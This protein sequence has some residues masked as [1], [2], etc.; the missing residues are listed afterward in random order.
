MP[1]DFSTQCAPLPI[2]SSITFGV[3]L[4]RAFAR[5]GTRASLDVFIRTVREDGPASLKK[6]KP[7]FPHKVTTFHSLRALQGKA[8][9]EIPNDLVGGCP[10]DAGRPAVVLPIQSVVFYPRVLIAITVDGVC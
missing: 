3:S 7:D 4:S 2:E 6:S 5:W 10:I 1:R 9:Q 8:A